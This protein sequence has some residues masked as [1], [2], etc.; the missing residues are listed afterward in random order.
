MTTSRSRGTE[1]RV[2]EALKEAPGYFCPK[3]LAAML[4]VK[5]TAVNAAIGQLVRSDRPRIVCVGT[6]GN[7]KIPGYRS[8]TR[9]YGLL[10]T[11]SLVEK[12]A[13]LPVREFR[14]LKRDFYEHWRLAMETRR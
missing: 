4:N 8:T 13:P 6:A 1:P 2:L 7:A 11:P 9:F 10:G 3:Q 12:S 5:V 14:P